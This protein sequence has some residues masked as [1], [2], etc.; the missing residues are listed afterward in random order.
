MVV[1]DIQYEELEHSCTHPWV[2]GGS[3]SHVYGSLMRVSEAGT[4]SVCVPS[5]RGEGGLSTERWLS[6][7]RCFFD[8]GRSRLWSCCRAEIASRVDGLNRYAY[9]LLLRRSR[10]LAHALIARKFSFWTAPAAS[11]IREVKV[12]AAQVRT[13]A[14]FSTS[15][16]LRSQLCCKPPPI[17]PD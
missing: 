6:H 2:R 1:Y 10:V 4:R 12:G 5:Q 3:Y 17:Q 14:C 15:A 13:G 7:S 16:Q 11:S 8:R 9:Q